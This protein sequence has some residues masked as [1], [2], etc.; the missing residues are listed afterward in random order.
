MDAEMALW[1]AQLGEQYDRVARADNALLAFT[2]RGPG[3]G[4]GE[5][6]QVPVPVDDDDDELAGPRPTGVDGGDGCRGDD[7][8]REPL[9]ATS[10]TPGV[11]GGGPSGAG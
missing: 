7:P 3:A 8:T 4:G 5:A 11:A 9:G 10:T 2:A 1:E 6:Q